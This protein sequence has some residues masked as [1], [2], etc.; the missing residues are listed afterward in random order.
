MP[1]RPK[2]NSESTFCWVELACTNMAKAKNFYGSVMGWKFKDDK[3]PGG[4]VYTQIKL[5]NKGLVGGLYEFSA[6]ATKGKKAKAPSLPAFWGSY[7]ATKNIEAT[8]QKA[9]KNGGNVALEIMDLG[10]SG[11]ISVIQDPVG[12][13]LGLWEKK[14][15]GGFGAALDK[16]GT[17]AWNELL[18]PNE[19][20]SLQFYNKVFNW[21][22]KDHAFNDLS[23]SYFTAKDKQVAG[24]MRLK[25]ELGEIP[26]H[27]L[28]YFNSDDV[29]KSTKLVVK[30]GGQVLFPP[31]S[32]KGVARMSV[33][34]DPEG[35]SF[36]LIKYV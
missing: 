26:S 35:A 4:G 17:A 20:E 36:A 27:W 10:Q 2:L 11:R 14:K 31:T 19:K 1:N 16:A 7:V 3:M 21:K 28:V 30:E 32:F 8:V 25:P 9:K 23:Y 34:M 5:G 22:L 15:Q 6:P 24:L 13:M 33:V 18:T 29:D 12:A